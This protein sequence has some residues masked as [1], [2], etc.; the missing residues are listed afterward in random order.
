MRDR[1]KDLWRRRVYGVFALGWYG[2][3]KQWQRYRIG[4]GLLGGFAT[5][6]VVSVHSIVS[7]D[8]A[9]SQLPGWHSLIFPPYFVA[10]AIF[11]GFAMVL[12]LML[13]ARKLYKLENVITRS[14]LD[15]MGKMIL[16]TGWI[17]LLRL[18]LSRCTAPGIRRTRSRS[19]RISQRR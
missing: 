19:M 10:G 12:T 11:S 14:H 15:N 13:P 18:H 1:A 2:S 5:P 9:I 6:L 7:M 16:L 8:F 4:Y 3:A 17:V